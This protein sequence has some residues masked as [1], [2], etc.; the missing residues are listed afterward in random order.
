MV[1][2]GYTHLITRKDGMM[3]YVDVTDDGNQYQI[4]FCKGLTSSVNYL[5]IRRDDNGDEM[6]V[7][8]AGYI[9]D[10]R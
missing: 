2:I 7:K 6:K 10:Y 3:I 1:M 8:M 5:R 9:L 4:K